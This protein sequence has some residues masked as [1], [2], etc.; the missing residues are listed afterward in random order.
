MESGISHP[1]CSD[2]YYPCKC[3]VP[4]GSHN[5]LRA[6]NVMANGQLGGTKSL[7]KWGK[8]A[9]ALFHNCDQ[10]NYTILSVGVVLFVTFCRAALRCVA[11][12]DWPACYLQINAL[13]SHLPVVRARWFAAR[14]NRH[15]KSPSRPRKAQQMNCK[16]RCGN[17]L[18]YIL[19]YTRFGFFSGF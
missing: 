16:R 8:I 18:C 19:F 17:T 11:L 4:R 3:R 14:G 7:A 10:F 5:N 2:S 15:I 13:F 9:H 6:C 1:R 12:H